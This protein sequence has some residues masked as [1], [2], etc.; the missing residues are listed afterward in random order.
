MSENAIQPIYSMAHPNAP[1]T[2]FSDCDIELRVPILLFGKGLVEF[3]WQPSSS[4][5]FKMD[6]LEGQNTLNFMRAGGKKAILNISA[7]YPISLDVIINRTHLECK[8]GNLPTCQ[9]EGMAEANRWN[10]VLCD[11]IRFHI[12]NMHAYIGAPITYP[13]KKSRSRISLGDDDWEIVIDGVENLDELIDSLDNEG[14]FAITHVGALKHKNGM[15]FKIADAL[16]H[17]KTLGFFLSF[18]EGR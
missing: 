1:I 12:T 15:T 16:E 10:D 14:G 13:T 17:M 11:E 7:N 6:P 18:V 5:H 8:S 9:L 3:R 4:L 2:L